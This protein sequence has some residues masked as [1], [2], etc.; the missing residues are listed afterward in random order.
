MTLSIPQ[1]PGSVQDAGKLRLSTMLP[2]P[3]DR[4]LLVGMTGSGKTTLARYL[5]TFRKYVVVADYKGRINWPGYD[6]CLSL[7]QAV[8]SNAD[9]II[10]RPS[11]AESIDDEY[12]NR[13][14]LWIWQRRNTT[15]YIDEL[16]AITKGE[17]YP[18]WYGACLG[19]GREWDIEVWSGTQRPTFIPGVVLSESEHVYAFRLRLER[20]R[21]R[22]ESLTGIAKGSI[23]KLRK[24]QFLYAPQDEEIQ[25]PLTLAL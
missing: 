15:A 5:L 20:D 22:V 6:L 12:R 9:R 8:K 4:A 21:E 2:R 17:V 3:T 16:S 25:G 10:Y 11:Y 14:W 24:L 18:L 23:Q 1:T 7:K 19:R 13:F